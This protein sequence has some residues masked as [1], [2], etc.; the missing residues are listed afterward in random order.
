[1]TK[2]LPLPTPARLSKLGRGL[3]AAQALKETLTI[4]L[5]GVPLVREEPVML[6][7]LL[8]GLVLYLLHWQMWRGR[9]RWRYAAVVW[10][11]TLLDELW[12]WEVF[13]ELAAPTQGQ[14]RLLHWSYFLGLGLIGLALAEIGWRYRRSRAKALGKSV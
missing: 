10:A 3:A 5:L 2:L 11:F 12:G 6:L 4:L 9:V 8:P 13:R 1:M 14:I 7:S